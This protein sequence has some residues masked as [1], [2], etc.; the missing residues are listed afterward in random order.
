M[1][2]SLHVKLLK[3]IESTLLYTAEIGVFAFYQAQFTIYMALLVC[4]R[5]QFYQIVFLLSPSYGQQ[6]STGGGPSLNT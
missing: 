3:N 4:P 1:V 5:R 2:I 6:S